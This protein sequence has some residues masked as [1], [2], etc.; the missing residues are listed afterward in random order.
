MKK[1]I[2]EVQMSI[3][4]FIAEVNG[5]TDWMLWNWGPD[6]QW[7]NELQKY[8][9]DLTK[10]VDCIFLSRQ[11]AEEGFIAHWAKASQ[12]PKDPRF[13][14]AK[15]ITDTHKIVFTKTIDKSVSIPGGWD[16]TDIAKGDFV[17]AINKLK[18]KKGKDIIVYGGAT[19]VSSLIRAKLVDEFHLLINPVAIGEGLPIFRDL[20]S[21]QNLTMVKSKGFDCGMVLLNYKQQADKTTNR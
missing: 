19:F 13:E 7:D 3:D 20:T 4:G 17:D 9:T 21:R 15:H 10:S 12:D 2:L 6:W 18:K 11:M 14:F 1:L 5:N 16:N 8:H